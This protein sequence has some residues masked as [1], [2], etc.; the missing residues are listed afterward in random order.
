MNGLIDG[1][2]NKVNIE[3]SAPVTAVEKKGDK[4]VI[5][6][7]SATYSASKVIVATGVNGTQSINIMNETKLEKVLESYVTIVSLGFDESAFE[8][9]I[10]GYGF[11][12]PSK[13]NTFVMGVL[14][15]SR[16]FAEH[17]PKGKVHL[18]CF[19][20]GARHPER[21]SM[22]E[23]QLISNI[24]SDLQTLV[25]VNGNPDFVQIMRNT[26]IGIPQMQ[27][28]H[29]KYVN[30][31]NEM[32]SKHEGLYLMGVGWNEISCS[33]LINEAMDLVE[34]LTTN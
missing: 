33:G 14:F 6:T 19:I 2:A 1:L 25:K 13:E 20:G 8:N 7:K 28:G 23:E 10:E 29:E 31:K 26:E 18:R 22:A 27:L 24:L 32:E 11:L 4:F 17:A 21:A 3:Y 5:S 9:P 34:K 16:L 15:T 30:W 12:S